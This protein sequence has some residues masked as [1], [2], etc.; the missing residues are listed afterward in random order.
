MR[1]G[2]KP[3]DADPLRIACRGQRAI[4]EESCAQQWCRFHVR[5]SLKQMKA[6]AAVGDRVLGVTAVDRIPRKTRFVA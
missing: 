2:A 5:I 6:V 3:V 1:G 4:A